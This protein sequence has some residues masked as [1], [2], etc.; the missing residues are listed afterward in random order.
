MRFKV[1]G[2]MAM[3]P[4]ARSARPSSVAK[5]TV[6]PPVPPRSFARKAL[7]FAAESAKWVAAGCPLRAEED[8]RAAEGICRECQPH[9]NVERNRCQL[10]GCGKMM[11]G[12]ATKHCPVGKW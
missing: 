7:S 1:Q 6:A 11:W 5:G 9:W 2:H 12:W 8:R 10:C 3:P 4:V